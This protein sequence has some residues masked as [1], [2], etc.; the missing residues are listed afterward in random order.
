MK[1]F[2]NRKLR[3]AVGSIRSDETDKSVKFLPGAILSSLKERLE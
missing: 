1:I 2:V 3:Y